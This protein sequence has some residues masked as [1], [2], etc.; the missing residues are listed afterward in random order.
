MAS[1]TAGAA[2]KPFNEKGRPGTGRPF[3][4]F[5]NGVP[6]DTTE[7]PKRQRHM[8]SGF[9]PPAYVQLVPPII[10]AHWLRADEL[11]DLCWGG[12]DAN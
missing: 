3:D 5:N 6:A 7:T 1:A 2:A 11:T 8:P 10:A 4:N 12:G 9:E